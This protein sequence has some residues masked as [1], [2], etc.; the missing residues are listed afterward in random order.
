MQYDLNNLDNVIDSLNEN[1]E[2]RLFVLTFKLI[3]TLSNIACLKKN[4]T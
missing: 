4:R 3:I 2:S 1:S